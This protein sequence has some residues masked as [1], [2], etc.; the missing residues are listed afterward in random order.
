MKKISKKWLR[1]VC[2]QKVVVEADMNV[3]G[4][5]SFALGVGKLKLS[6]HDRLWRGS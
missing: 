2:R 1:D 4:G 6:K 5:E 3:S